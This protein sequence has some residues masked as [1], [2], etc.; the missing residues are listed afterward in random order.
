MRK[1]ARRH[2]IGQLSIDSS[3]FTHYSKQTGCHAKEC[4]LC[5]IAW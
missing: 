5:V 4:T 2:T 3:Q 1:C